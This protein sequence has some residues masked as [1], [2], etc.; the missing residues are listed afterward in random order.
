MRIY[1]KKPWTRVEKV[2]LVSNYY[3]IPKADTY[4]LLPN[5]TPNAITKQVLYLRSKGWPFKHE[6]KS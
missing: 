4:A 2:I 1:K 6:S 3:M 5:R